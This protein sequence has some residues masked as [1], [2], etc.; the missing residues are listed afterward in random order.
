LPPHSPV[1]GQMAA[2]E[3]MFARDQKTPRQTDQ[4]Q[5]VCNTK[6]AI[7]EEDVVVWAQTKHIARNIRPIVRSTQ[8]TDMRRLCIGTSCRLQADTANL[9]LIIM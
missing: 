6:D 7:V 8:R 5:V 1:I 9:A 2:V 4:R 3:G